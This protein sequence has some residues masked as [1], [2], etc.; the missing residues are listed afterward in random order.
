MPLFLVRVPFLSDPYQK[1]L[2][3]K[4]ALRNYGLFQNAKLGIGLKSLK[5]VIIIVVIQLTMA[6]KVYDLFFVPRKCLTELAKGELVKL[7]NRQTH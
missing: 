2:S 5:S 3:C 4:S 6:S 7:I 1:F